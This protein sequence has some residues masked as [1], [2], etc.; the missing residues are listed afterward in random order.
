M[1][2]RDK[3][4]TSV[5]AGFDPPTSNWFRMPNTWTDITA[6]ITSVAEL[7]VVEY[8]LRHTWGYQ[9]YGLKKH[10]TIDEFVN[11]RRHHDT[12]RMDKGTGLSERAVY[13]G[14]RKAV[15]HGLIEEEVDDSDRGRVKKYYC[16]K[17]REPGAAEPDRRDL[18]TLQPG[19]QTLHPPLQTMQAR[20]ARSAPRTE[21]ETL[22]RTNDSNIRMA[23]R[24]VDNSATTDDGRSLHRPTRS[25]GWEAPPTGPAT[26]GSVVATLPVGAAIAERQRRRQDGPEATAARVSG[27]DRGDVDQEPSAPRRSRLRRVPHQDE[28]YQVI[29]AYIADFSRELNDKAPLKTSTMRAYNLYRRSGLD[30]GAFIDQL[31]AARA[32]VKERTASIRTRGEATA[33]GVPTKNKAAYYFAV[34]EDLLGLREEAEQ[35]PSSVELGEQTRPTAPRRRESSPDQT[36]GVVRRR[37]SKHRS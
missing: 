22:E 11:G 18:Q 10:I 8:I 14:L 28:A 7:K 1:A 15:E 19:V 31:Y 34:L 30:Q 5:F 25:T 17:R 23:S 32:I 27:R 9:E 21:K 37:W 24:D 6:E 3:E 29:Q 16:L 2:R 4:P 36:E 13:D 26:V 12:T 20:G 33:A 35:A